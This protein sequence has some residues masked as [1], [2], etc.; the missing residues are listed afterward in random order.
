M[1]NL[2][3]NVAKQWCTWGKHPNYILS[4]QALRFYYNSISAPL[5]AISID[6]DDFAPLK[7]VDWMS[8][9][10]QNAKVKRIHLK[11]IDFNSKSMGHFGIFKERFKNSIWLRFLDEIKSIDK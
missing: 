9:Q 7:A 10:F 1:E 4:D 6:D 11:P 3:K 2:P 8:G 5:T